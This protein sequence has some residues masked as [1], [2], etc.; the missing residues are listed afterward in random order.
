MGEA[1]G[2]SFGDSALGVAT[3]LAEFIGG[4]RPGGSM[5]AAVSA[6]RALA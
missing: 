1:G 3:V 4:M 5:L 2:A 6:R